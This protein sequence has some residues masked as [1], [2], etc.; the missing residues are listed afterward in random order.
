MEQKKTGAQTRISYAI[1]GLLS[2]IAISILVIHSTFIPTPQSSFFTQNTSTQA[3]SVRG[4]H[5]D[6]PALEKFN[7]LG[8]QEKYDNEGLFEKI[9]GKAPLYI[10]NGFVGLISQRYALLSDSSRW[11]EFYLY[12]MESNKNAFAVFSS[13]R[14][15]GS[16]TL[17]PFKEF[18]HY[19]T[20]NGLFLRL[21]KY[22]IELIG[23]DT[24]NEIQMGMAALSLAFLQK[25]TIQNTP[26]EELVFFPKEG[27]IPTSFRL[28]QQNAFGSEVLTN[29]V[30]AQY[31]INGQPV[32]AYISSQKDSHLA[33]QA[34]E[35]YYRFLIDSGG[36]PLKGGAKEVIR[37]VDLFGTVESLFVTNNF[38]AGVHEAD[39]LQHAEK[40][41]KMLLKRLQPSNPQ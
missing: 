33:N 37:Y 5:P 29:T 18:D 4:D 1:L 14:R 28:Y 2:V 10:D 39:D 9:N 24:S 40:L 26:I 35:G 3:A 7:K 6:I 22:Y 17:K 8:P 20:E 25:N 34:F 23:S 31:T 11:F 16:N 12:N 13:Q 19:Q 38:I 41:S 27:L 36:A 32:T 21:G 30:V 15:P